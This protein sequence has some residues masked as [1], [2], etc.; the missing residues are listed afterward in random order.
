MK[1]KKK[2]IKIVFSYKQ[3]LTLSTI[4]IVTLKTEQQGKE[5]N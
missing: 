2:K 4:I 5:A 3:N 1:V